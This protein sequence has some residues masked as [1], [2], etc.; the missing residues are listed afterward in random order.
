MAYNRISARRGQEVNLDI[1]FLRGGILTDP[2]AI[3]R[4]E[5]FRGSV[6]AE[7]IVDAIEVASP[8]SSSYPYPL[9]RQPDLDD[10]P[11]V[12]PSPPDCDDGSTS[13]VD[14]VGR[15][16][17][18][19]DVPSD[20]IVPDV[21]FDVWY[22][23]STDPRTG[24]GSGSAD[25]LSSHEE[26][27]LSQCNRFWVYPD[28]WYADGGLDTIRLGFEPLDIKFRKPERRPVE[29]GIMPL[30]LYDYNYNLVAPIIPYLEPTISIWTEN[31]EAIISNAACTIKIRQGS[32]RSNPWVI[33]YM[34][35]TCNFF[36]GT[37]KYRVK[38][39]LPDG[40]SRVSGDYYLTV[41]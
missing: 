12:C 18:V 7:N 14:N 20:A 3:Y 22:W 9:V 11:V 10:P 30:P 5:I 4:I 35:D 26:D 36:I 27:L 2:F 39:A 40:T 31:G 23:F 38:V 37:Y 1:S 34:L 6:A 33:S 24:S 13:V 8:D 16:R 17:L 15:F 25:E 32:Y 29:V 21:Y 28:D 41:S 19:W